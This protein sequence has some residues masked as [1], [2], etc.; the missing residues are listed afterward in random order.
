MLLRLASE[1][2]LPPRAMQ[3]AA[4]VLPANPDLSVRALA[5]EFF[6]PASKPLLPDA[7]EVLRLAGVPSRGAQ[8][9]FGSAAQCETCHTYHGQ[10]G[11]VGPDLTT[12]AV[13]Y[14]KPEILDAL[15]HPSKAIA[16]GYDAWLIETKDGLLES[17]FLLADG[18][19][20]VL[21]DTAGKR[22]VIPADEIES[23]TKQTVST[24]PDGVALGLSK[25]DLADLLEFLRTDPRAPGKRLPTRKL[26][27][28]K[29]LD[30]WTF[31]LDDPKAKMEDTWSVEDGV[32]R[33]KGTPIGYLRT[34]EDFTSF[35]LTLEWRF[36]PALPPGNSGVLMRM[37]GADQVWPNSI[38]AQLHH[39]NAGD[40]W[41][42][43]LFAMQVDPS[44]TE[45]RRTRKAHPCNEKPI[46]EW[47]RYVITLDGGELTLEVN[48]EVQNTAHWAAEVAGKIC[49][50]S[51]GAAIEFRN[52]EITPIDR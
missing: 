45:G 31:F 2:K 46:G 44:R 7:D 14:G 12:I 22:H 26:F 28:G 19:P 42:I 33:C 38:E 29:D 24:M 11:D 37:T 8:I 40:I 43:G 20:V 52:I 16:H 21:K 27:N 48:G 17:G 34:K 50:Q 15:L 41:N 5:T 30:G 51:E 10:G 25:Q 13:K 23:R 39:R 49:L 1:K 6:S 18:D 32:L 47:N 35:V 9:F 4:R 3:A 36:D